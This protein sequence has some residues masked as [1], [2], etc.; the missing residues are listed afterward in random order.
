M[1]NYDL[2][3][4][5]KE[6]MEIVWDADHPLMIQ[7]ILD[8]VKKRYDKEWRPQT[9]SSFLR[10]LVGKGLLNY[11][12]KNMFSFYWSCVGRKEYAGLMQEQIL[13]EWFHN[14]KEEFLLTFIKK[15]GM[16]RE[17]LE[18]IIEKFDL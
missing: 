3:K 13:K 1:A 17:T 15:S 18:G 8:E 10:S 4:S 14:S 6:I 9:L 11:H 2:T 12:R 5:E 7:E 16:T